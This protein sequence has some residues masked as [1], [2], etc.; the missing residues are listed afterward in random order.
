[1]AHIYSYLTFNGN[2]RKAMTFY[3]HCL[4]GELKF[5]T[6][7]ETPLTDKMTDK[8]KSYI[9][10]ATLTKGDLILIATD[11]V[12]DE[13]LTKGNAVSLLLNCSSEEELNAYY[14]KLSVGAKATQA[15]EVNFWD[16]LFASITDEFGNN[17]L[18]N[19][20]RN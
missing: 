2:C 11:L 5:Q 1:M 4:G 12:T 19:Y 8:M 14:N 9:V 20:N 6:I 15:A 13:G 10:Q 18:L 7:G 17:W 3:Q 16:T